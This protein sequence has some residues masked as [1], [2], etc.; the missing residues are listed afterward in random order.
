MLQLLRV[1]WEETNSRGIACVYA[2]VQLKEQVTEYNQYN[3]RAG[4]KNMPH[5]NPVLL[6]GDTHVGGRGRETGERFPG[7]KEI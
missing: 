7:E 2:T 4:K 6:K 3:T 5:T 1:T